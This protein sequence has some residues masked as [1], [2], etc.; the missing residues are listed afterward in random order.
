MI[1]SAF[2]DALERA[3]SRAASAGAT[4][5]V[6]PTQAPRIWLHRLYDPHPR[7][8]TTAASREARMDHCRHTTNPP[9]GS[10]PPARGRTLSESEAAALRL[11]RAQGAEWLPADFTRHELKRAFR[12]VAMR[13][14]P[15]R[16]PFL[17]DEGRQRQAHLFGEIRRAFG[18][19]LQTAAV[20]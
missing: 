1:E 20:N 3:L 2:G 12:I 8:W 4:R 10:P 9:T 14:H 6:P 11:L 18:L 7:T 17:G 13:C 16:H 5:P 15:D 19:L